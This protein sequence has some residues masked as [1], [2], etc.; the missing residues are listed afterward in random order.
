M[1]LINLRFFVLLLLAIVT[2]TSC[3]DDKD[4]EEAEP[5]KKVL[6]VAHE[7]QGDQVLMMGI[8]VTES[9][10]IPQDAPDVRTLRLTFNEDNTYVAKSDELAFEGE[11]QFNE[12]ETK[13][14]FDFLALGEV[15]VKKLTEDKLNLST[16]VSKTQL[17][18]LAQLL[19]LD[20]GPLNNLP[21][22]TKIEV[23]IRFVKP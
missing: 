11:W 13:I 3:K 7:W 9:G 12:D 14:Y 8:N 22:G 16:N 23:E 17:T 6:L 21:D 5:S 4:E 20:L 1:K 18:L 2:F 10:A 15:D 19:N